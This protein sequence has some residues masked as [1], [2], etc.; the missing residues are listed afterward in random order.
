MASMLDII[1]LLTPA[2]CTN[3]L[4][5]DSPARPNRATA[6]P[7]SITFTAIGEIAAATDDDDEVV[8]VEDDWVVAAICEDEGNRNAVVDTLANAGERFGWAPW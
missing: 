6:E 4:G 7:I 5:Y 1:P 8:V 2:D 3:V